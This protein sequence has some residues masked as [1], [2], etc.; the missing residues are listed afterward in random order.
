VTPAVDIFAL[1]MIAFTLL[2]GKAYWHDEA[3]SAGSVYA[4]VG[5]VMQGLRESARERAQRYGVSLPPAFDAWFAK[6]T[7]YTPQDRFPTASSAIVALGEV[8]GITVAQRS[9]TH[10]GSGPRPAPAVHAPTPA[11][12]ELPPRPWQAP[13]AEGASAA[14]GAGAV[15][16]VPAQPM[17]WAQANASRAE[18]PSSPELQR[19]STPAH[20]GAPRELAPPFTRGSSLPP[21]PP[22]G[23]AVGST[24][25]GLVRTGPIKTRASGTVVAVAVA[26]TVAGA[27]AAGSIL[28]LRKEDSTTP[29]HGAAALTTTAMS[30]STQ[31]PAPIEVVPAPTQ[32]L[33]PAAPV[34]TASVEPA[35][36]KQALSAAPGPSVVVPS[37]PVAT[38]EPSAVK[39]PAVAGVK[40]PPEG[41]PKKP[42]A[43]RKP[44][45]T[46]D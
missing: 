35:E 16:T 38:T 11:P 3:S 4:F 2:T 12:A 9:S 46:L 19:A 18:Q 17:P 14:Y 23:V 44:A 28:F 1:G 39:K 10:T 5:V 32:Q 45:M 7:A 30:A 29:E 21:V 31:G 8:F 26:V 6:V 13:P 36:P 15:A 27:I 20:V 41:T 22:M 34:V 25:A 37:A 40:S 24:G 43:P 42:Q 33:E